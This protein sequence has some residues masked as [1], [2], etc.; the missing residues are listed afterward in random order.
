METVGAYVLYSPLNLT[1][2][3]SYRYCR[4]NQC[5]IA[6]YAQTPGPD[7]AGRPLKFGSEPQTVTDKIAEWADWS[8]VEPPFSPQSMQSKGAGDGYWTGFET[9]S[10]LRKNWV[11]PA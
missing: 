1:A 10:R 6:D 7:H 9:A 4:N 11:I 2:N 3:F 8:S 5:G